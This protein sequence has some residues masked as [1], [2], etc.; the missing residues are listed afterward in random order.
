MKRM[1]GRIIGVLGILALG[2]L[3][4][5]EQAGTGGGD[6]SSP[7]DSSSGSPGGQ[8]VDGALVVTGVLNDVD[9]SYLD[10]DTLPEVQAVQ[11]TT[12][13]LTSTNPDDNN[14][15]VVDDDG[16][17]DF[18]MEYSQT[19]P[20][21]AT[22]DDYFEL[23]V[24]GL[25]VSNTEATLTAAYV[26]ILESGGDLI[27]ITIIDIGSSTTMFEFYV[28]SSAAT[29]VTGD[30]VAD[31]GVTETYEMTLEAG[32]NLGYLIEGGNVATSTTTRPSDFDGQW[33]AGLEL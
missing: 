6:D 33:Y 19:P 11:L 20:D 8:I 16:G 1:T 2:I 28:Y 26:E 9:H 27:P 21:L 3:V 32:W 10:G 18:R 31:D 22:T 14:V 23:D 17:D 30:Y 15:L 12:Y 13:T 5:C 25:T 29:T 4:G 7:D 24:T